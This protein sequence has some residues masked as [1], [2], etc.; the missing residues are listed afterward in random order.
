MDANRQTDWLTLVIPGFN[1]VSVIAQAIREAEAALHRC[2]VST[3]CWSLTTV[4]RT[5]RCKWSTDASPRAK[6]AAPSAR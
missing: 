6:H 3:K 1:E 4:A 5:I 2:L